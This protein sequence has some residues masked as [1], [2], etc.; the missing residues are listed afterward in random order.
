MTLASTINYDSDVGITV[1]ER[2]GLNNKKGVYYTTLYRANHE[3]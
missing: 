3:S 1:S 2:T